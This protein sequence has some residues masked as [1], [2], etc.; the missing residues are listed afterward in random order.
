[1]NAEIE[2]LT[3]TGKIIQGCSHTARILNHKYRRSVI[4]KAYS[5]LGKI[6]DLHYDAIAF[7]GVSGSM[8]VP[9]IA[10]LLKKNIILIRKSNENCYSDFIVEGCSTDYY[11]IV[12]D[13]ICSGGTAQ[14]IIDN[15]H[16]EQPSAKCVG[17]YS[18]M[19]DQCSGATGK[20]PYLNRWHQRT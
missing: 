10:S 7:C 15:I 16:E 13:L 2:R 6:K 19:P 20:I 3:E 12:D 18:Y 17:I 11:I 5:D 9:E 14:Y 1:M 8:V 4:V